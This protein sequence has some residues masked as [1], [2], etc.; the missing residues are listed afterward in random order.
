MKNFTI[1][2]PVKFFWKILLP[3][4]VIICVV[5]SVS[6]IWIIDH[7]V[8]PQIVGVNRDI[9]EVPKVIGMDI[10]KAREKFFSVGLLTEIRS[11]EY[12]NQ[13]PVQS[14]ISQFPDVGEKVK[15]GRKIAVVV[16]KGK[17]IAVIPDV[18]N[19]SE[20]QAR[21]VLKKNGFTLGN[22]VKSFSDDKPVDVIIDAFP[23]SGTTVSREIEVDLY[24]SKGPRPTHAEAPNLV[25]ESIGSAKKKIEESGLVVGKINYQNNP[26]LLPGTVISQS[27]APGSKVPLD[28]KVNIVVSVIR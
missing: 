26:S 12:D 7:L 14:V 16:S 18:R 25:G 2:I 6:G 3:A 13:I 24:V 15:K 22:V 27:V 21:M 19:L 1:N 4:A 20:R 9:V 17:E 8:M 11:K 28:S 10:E 5:G 23:K